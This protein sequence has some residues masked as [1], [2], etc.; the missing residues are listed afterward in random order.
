MLN[1]VLIN[2]LGIIL[3][4]CLGS[5]PTSVWISKYFFKIDIRNYG[6]GNAGATNALRVLGPKVGLVVLFFD[7]LK[8]WLAIEL[9]R[10]FN[11]GL[12]DGFK[13]NYEIWLGVAVV[14][15]HVLPAFANFKG[16]KG[17]ATL[18]GV[19]IALYPFMIYY[20][21]GVFILV[22][23][24]T[25]IVSISSIITSISFPIIL[26]IFFNGKPITILFIAFAIATALFVPFTHKKNIYRLLKGEEPKFTLKK[27]K[28]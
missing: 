19:L 17:I 10:I 6:S 7:V 2:A 22:F 25:R 8:G 20:L 9:A 24:I 4:Y 26:L 1:Q 12:H 13:V 27:K 21:L 3:A 28:E 15:G 11:I 18:L 5:I 16:G 14:A 23:F